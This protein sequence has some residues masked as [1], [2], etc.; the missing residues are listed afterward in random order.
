MKNVNVIEG[1]KVKFLGCEDKETYCP[2]IGTI[3]TVVAVEDDIL[4]VEWDEYNSVGAYRVFN[5][6]L[7]AIK[8]ECFELM[9]KISPELQ[10]ILSSL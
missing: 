1:S 10:R 3:C 4:V 5:T 6:H 7:S 2:E 8:R 9:P